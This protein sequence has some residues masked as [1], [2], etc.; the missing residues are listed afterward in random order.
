MELTLSLLNDVYQLTE[1]VDDEEITSV[2][3]F[4]DNG[5]MVFLKPS[6][7]EVRKVSGAWSVNDGALNPGPY[8]VHTPV[9]LL[10]LLSRSTCT[11]TLRRCPHYLLWATF[12]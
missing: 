8:R 5:E 10:N 9:N 1:S 4:T 12:L 2:V 3:E 11:A 6:T 7:E